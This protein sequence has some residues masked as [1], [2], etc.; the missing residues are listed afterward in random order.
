MPAPSAATFARLADLVAIPDASERPTRA[1]LEVFTGQKLAEI[2]IGTA[3][4]A[5]DA[6]ARARVAQ[7]EWADRPVAERAAVFHRYRDLVLKNL[8]SLMDMAQ[9]E[10][11]KSRNAAQEE[12]LDIAMTARH[13][14]RVAPKLLRPQRVTGMLPGLDLVHDPLPV[15]GR[16]VHGVR[17]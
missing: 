7:K 13:Y 14:A 6:I 11:G 1:V 8:D 9:A 2:P 12:I 15:L 10:T 4:D 17:A 16:L 5:K 3:Q